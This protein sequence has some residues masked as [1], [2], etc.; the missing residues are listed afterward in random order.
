MIIRYP[1]QE[2]MISSHLGPAD[3]PRKQQE[4]EPLLASDP[5]TIEALLDHLG[6][7]YGGPDAYF[8]SIGLAALASLRLMGPAE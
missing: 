2:K 5:R 1:T 8:T 7:E 3:T 6:T 4:I